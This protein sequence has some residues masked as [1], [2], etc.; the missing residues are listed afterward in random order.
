MCGVGV[1]GYGMKMVL[2]EIFGMKSDSFIIPIWMKVYLAAGRAHHASGEL[3]SSS[4]ILSVLNHT[5]LLWTYTHL[6]VPTNQPTNQHT[7]QP[8]NTPTNAQTHKPPQTNT[9]TPKNQTTVTGLP[10]FVFTSECHT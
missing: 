2:D 9:H 5:H 8:N 7:H 1:L 4:F 3:M 6:N 10:V